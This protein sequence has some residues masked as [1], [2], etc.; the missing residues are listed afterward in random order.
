M[1]VFTLCAACSDGK[2][3]EPEP[4]PPTPEEQDPIVPE[5]PNA[6]YNGI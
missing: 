5:D 6:L 2:G 4:I 1:A 3:D